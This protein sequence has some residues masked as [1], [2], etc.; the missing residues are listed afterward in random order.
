MFYVM[1]VTRG[2]PIVTKIRIVPYKVEINTLCGHHAHSQV[3]LSTD[4]AVSPP[5]S[6]I[7]FS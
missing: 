1:K 6:L 3:S 7:G 5:K 2:Q 4:N